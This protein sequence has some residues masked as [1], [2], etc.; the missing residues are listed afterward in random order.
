MSRE[1]RKPLGHAL[2]VM[3]L[4][5]SVATLALGLIVLLGWHIDNR[6]LIQVLPTF[7]PMQYNTA[8][9]FV[10]CGA[11]LLGLLL[12]RF[13]LTV[14][15]GYFVILIGGLTIVEYIAGVNLGIDELLMKHEVTVETSHPGRMAPNTALCFMLVGLA[16]ALSPRGWSRARRSL[17]HVIL[18]SLAFGLAIVALSG[19]FAKLETAY[20]WGN[21]TRMAVHTSAGFIIASISLLCIVWSRDLRDV[22]WL[23]RWIPVPTFVGILT[24]ALCFWQAMTAESA[25]IAQQYE[26]LGSLSNL[27]GMMLFVGALLALAM[28]T[29]AWLAQRSGLRAREILQANRALEHARE[30]TLTELL[31][32]TPDAM[33]IAN[34]EGAICRCNVQVSE[35]FGYDR[36]ELKGMNVERLM[37]ELLRENHM[38]HLVTYFKYPDVR[39]MGAGMELLGLRKDGTQFPIEIGLSPFNDPQGIMAVAALR[40]ISDR[41]KAEEEIKLARENAEAANRAKSQFLSNMSHELRTPLNGVLGYAQI[42]RRDPTLSKAHRANL[43]AIESCGEH[44]LQLINDVLDLSKIEAGRLEIDEAPCDLHRLLQSVFDI[45]SPRAEAKGLDIELEVSPTVPRAIVTDS[46][47]LKQALVN[48]LGNSVKFTEQGFVCLAVRD[49][50]GSILELHVRDTGV[51][52][53][54]EELDNIFDPFKQTELGKASGGTGLGLSI[55]RKLIE[56]QGGTLTVESTRGEGS[57]FTIRL[58]FVEARDEHFAALVEDSV[59][60][61]RGATL[62]E[63][64]DFCVL[65]VDDRQANRDIL[66]Q[67]LENTGFKTVEA[68][69]GREAIECMMRRKCDLV[70]MDV[71]MP[72]MNGIE[73]VQYIRND[74]SLKNSV[75]IAVTAS[76]FPEFRHTAV[77]AGFDDCL[78]KPLRAS[79]LFSVI[80][81]HVGVEFV[82]T[83]S[84]HTSHL[85][86]AV[87]VPLQADRANE[88]AARLAEPL[89]QH[90]LTAINAVAS[91]LAQSS[92][93]AFYGERI[94]YLA[95]SFDFDALERLAAELQEKA[96]E[97]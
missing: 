65:V 69:N 72:V 73:A 17:V 47:K 83:Q 71:R 36:N 66:V 44:L 91:D 22:S 85:P 80:Q 57:C 19:Y 48:L 8:L 64:Q 86:A 10:S 13:R 41:K 95:G 16:F 81:K 21:L 25:R 34:E 79:E 43:G 92:D 60:T 3:G 26:D 42:L 24:A 49:A 55:S 4:T 56:A 93:A 68:T 82:E 58:P 62:A 78:G 89:K 38:E 53:S 61:T 29:A 9:G 96:R 75:V 28:S 84:D 74:E 37:P 1:H 33:I 67:L 15:S 31:E 46:T 50:G 14:I 51:G 94:A 87:D 12:N 90:N 70:L 7:V 5:T 20:G 11:S 54:A 59:D 88:I 40:D 39:E 32:S 76:V 77:E 63:G 45:V 18:G 2:W 6:T 27:A 52:I 23:P 35:L 97:L 30:K